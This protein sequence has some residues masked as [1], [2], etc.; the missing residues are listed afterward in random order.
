M[1]EGSDSHPLLELPPPFLLRNHQQPHTISRQVGQAV[2]FLLDRLPC[3]ACLRKLT[4]EEG[5]F[6]NKA[7]SVF[8]SRCSLTWVGSAYN[9]SVF[10]L[11]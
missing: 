8:M 6:L 10:M 11:P 3:L 9:T 1:V 2:K 7:L 4:L 5:N